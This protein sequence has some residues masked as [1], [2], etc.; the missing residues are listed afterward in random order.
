MLERNLGCK[1]SH[2][3]KRSITVQSQEKLFCN[4]NVSQVGIGVR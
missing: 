3:F 4:V 2:S 1:K